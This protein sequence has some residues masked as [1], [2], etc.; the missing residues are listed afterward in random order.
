MNI[1]NILRYYFLRTPDRVA[2]GSLRIHEFTA[3]FAIDDHERVIELINAMD[4]D[5]AKVYGKVMGV[6]HL[7]FYV[8]EPN[9]GTGDRKRENPKALILAIIFDGDADDLLESLMHHAGPAV[10][11]VL[12]LCRGYSDAT[13]PKEFLKKRRIRSGFLFR[14][15]GT[16]AGPDDDPD[17]EG[18]ASVS[19]IDEARAVQS[20]FESFYDANFG[21]RSP[22]ALRSKFLAAF[23]ERRTT[24]KLTRF[25][26]AVPTEARYVRKVI[27]LNRRTQEQSRIKAGL[28][29]PLRGQHAKTHALVRARFEVDESVDPRFR[30]GVFARPGAVYGAWIRPSNGAPE[31]AADSAM[32][33]RGFTLRLE[34]DEKGAPASGAAPSPSY[35]DF[36]LFSHP[37]FFAPNIKDFAVLMSIF[38]TGTMQTRLPKAIAYAIGS[39]TFAMIF[40]ILKTL[41]HKIRHPLAADFHSAT[42]YLLGP[43]TPVKYSVEARDKAALDRFV[44]DTTD[45]D[46]R[47]KALGASLAAGPI[48]LDFYVYAYA[49]GAPVREVQDAVEDA[50]VDWTRSQGSLKYGLSR[51]GKSRATKVHLATLTLPRI[52]DGGQ[53][54]PTTARALAAAEELQFNPWNALDAHRP[55]GSLN[56]ARWFIYRDSQKQRAAP[57]SES[58][59]A[60]PERPQ[61]EHQ[62]VQVLGK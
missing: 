3:L 57:K 42:P 58:A 6:H 13:D 14:D 17:Y 2:A 19:E 9:Q 23:K 34:L 60:A 32:D 52:G 11:E 48:V 38:Q 55:L 24:L 15:L 1:G 45:P 39:G 54:D 62:V 16:L 10:R 50:S 44:E 35:Q 40:T 61:V 53:V 27:E 20:E 5:P 47:R 41:M 43:D 56:R 21:E 4:E 49:Q 8:F 25:E 33:A 59:G 18:D 22:E 12:R 28:E 29:R 30:H 31:R 36:L 46:F 7:R 26:R 51:W 37:T